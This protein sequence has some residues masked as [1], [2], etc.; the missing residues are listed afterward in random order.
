VPKDLTIHR[1]AAAGF[2]TAA[3][4]YE[5]GRPGY[6][7][8]AIE[9]LVRE[10]GIETGRHVLDL[11]AG[12]GKLTRLLVPTGA[13]LVAVEPVPEMRAGLEAAVPGIRA[14]GGTAEAIPLRDGSVDA[15]V[16]GQ[17]FHWFDGERALPEIRRVL[18]P[19]GGLGL[20]WQNRDASVGWVARLDELIDRMA[21]SEPRFRTREWERAF[22]RTH[23]F[24]PL[25][26]ATFSYIQRGAPAMIE[27]R[28]ASISYIAAASAEDRAALLADVRALLATH[29]TTSGA[30]TIEL[31]YVTSVFWTRAVR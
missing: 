23:L 29:P 17:A 22:E 18:R 27:D 6:P 30:A 10:L 31:P 3:E 11:A 28:V 5:R 20:I 1:A 2:A 9:L 14:L 12:T 15:V 24:E 19:G 13:S 16:V 8:E 26:E 4:A 21:T 25:H 7:P